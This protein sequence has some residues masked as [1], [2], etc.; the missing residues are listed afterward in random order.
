VVKTAMTLRRLQNAQVRAF[1]ASGLPEADY[2]RWAAQFNS[3]QDPVGFG[4]DMMDVKDRKK[5]IDGL[6]KAGKARLA[7]SLRTA[8]A[9]GLISMPGQ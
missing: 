5:Y 9:L 8:T 7:N 1:E 3:T 6:D 4:I 2:N